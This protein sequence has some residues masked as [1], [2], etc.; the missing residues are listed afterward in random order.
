M[1][2]TDLRTIDPTLRVFQFAGQPLTGFQS[3]ESA[4]V[5]WNAERYSKR[6]GLD[7]SHTRYKIN[8]FS[9]RVTFIL[10]ES[11][12]SNA[13]LTARIAAPGVD[14]ADA[15]PLSITDLNGATEY[16]CP[17]AYIMVRPT[18]SFTTEGTA[19]EWSIE[20][21]VMFGGPLGLPLSNL[22]L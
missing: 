11:S 17:N 2:A 9:A 22:I 4:R 13:L 6:V 14:L 3:G 19:I 1:A 15:G 12:P 7:G 16:F 20:C 5:E 10:E 21:P 18:H 8:D